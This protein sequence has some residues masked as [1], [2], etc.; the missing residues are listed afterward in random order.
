VKLTILMYHRVEETPRGETHPGNYVA[1]SLFQEQL[2]ALREWGYR[3]ITLADWIDYARGG[4]LAVQKPLIITFDDGYRSVL[5]HASTSLRHYG[6]EAITFLV[7]SCV[8]GTNRWDSAAAQ[9]RLLDADELRTLWSEGMRFGSHSRTHRRLARLPLDEARDELVRSRSELQTLLGSP[10]TALSYPYS[11]ESP[12]IRRLARESGYEVAVRGKGRMNRRG[13][14]LFALNRS[15]ID[16]TMSI[17]RLRH[18]LLRERW[19]RL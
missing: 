7:S 19:L 4:G 17:S 5:R 15:R 2:D 6:F 8:G 10:V 16:N 9:E 1:P 12:A 13:A 14:D 3:S 11:N 18:M